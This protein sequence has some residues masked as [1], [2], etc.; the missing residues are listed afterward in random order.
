MQRGAASP[1]QQWKLLQVQSGES[2]VV[3]Y[4]GSAFS[5]L[6]VVLSEGCEVREAEPGWRTGL[7]GHWSWK[8]LPALA[9]AC[10]PFLPKPH[11]HTPTIWSWAALH[12]PVIENN[13]L[14]AGNKNQPSLPFLLDTPF[15]AVKRWLMQYLQTLR[16]R[17][18]LYSLKY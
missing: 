14:K 8:V 9:P 4:S 15:P 6:S 7:T 5:A 16:F 17:S 12:L 1:L 18:V 2:S 10:T 13:L 3:S 11:E